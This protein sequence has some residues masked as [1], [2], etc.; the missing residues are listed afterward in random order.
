MK[1]LLSLLTIPTIATSMPNPLLAKAPLGRAKLDIDKTTTQLIRNK[2][3]NNQVYDF[4]IKNLQKVKFIISKQKNNITRVNILKEDNINL[5]GKLSELI[6]LENLSF[7][8]TQELRNNQDKQE[9]IRNL[10]TTYGK[11]IQENSTHETWVIN[12]KTMIKAQG[13]NLKYFKYGNYK[14][15]YQLIS[16]NNLEIE[17]ERDRD[18]IDNLDW[19]KQQSKFNLVDNNKTMTWTRPD[20][21]TVKGELN[22]VIANPNIDKVVF[23]NI[24]QNQTNKQWKINVKPETSEREHNLQVTFALNGKQYTSEIIVS[25]LAKIEPT[26]AP[27]KK[28]LSELIKKPDLGNISDNKNDNI[29]LAVNKINN[30][31]IDDFSQIEFTKKDNHSVTL[32][33]KKDSK[34]YQG[35]VVVKYNV[36]PSTVVDLKINLQP[37]ATS[38]SGVVVDNDYLAQLDKNSITNPVNKFHYANSESII[39]MIKS[40]PSSVITGVVYGCDEQW[41]KT[42]QQRTIDPVT[43]IK[44]DGIQLNT[45]KGKY[46]IELKNEL[47]QTS[48][49][50]LQING[51]KAKKEYWNTDNGKHFEQW[52][53]DNGYKNIRGSSA[54]QLNNLFALSKT[55]KQSLAHLKLQLDNFVV[56][57]IKNVTQDEINTYKT[58]LLDDVK[59]QVEK[60]VPDVIENIDYKVLADNLVAGDW[61]TSKDVKVQAVNSSTKLL[62]F[63]AKTI[64]VQQKE[65]PTLPTP[66][67]DPTPDNKKVGDS[68]L[69]IIGVVVGVLAGVGLA[70]LL[71]RKFIFNKY[72]L[73]KI[74]ARRQQKVVEQWKRDNHNREE[75]EE[76]AR[77][78]QER[79]E[80]QNKQN[81]Q[82]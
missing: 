51:E 81:D 62:S 38:G 68:K 37:T 30:D 1:K 79:E 74:Y 40:N 72:I 73:P 82:R 20:L 23:D 10:I 17:I 71:F 75:A 13:T 5:N 60:Y 7:S 36:V 63:T 6:N 61:T 42:P 65:Q 8:L 47:N 59:S 57:D 16:T 43:G 64:P 26:R 25:M 48:T 19:V 33:A 28:Q 27:V 50:Y 22:I 52:A 78:Q 12:K 11:K 45:V 41:N 32:T 3:Q 69:W 80:K 49:I 56:D 55:W 2:R 44:L 66:T 77:K 15:N 58:K 46:L 67:F 54:S 29:F 34:S 76:Q 9:K 4:E 35:S 31:I 53:E 39:K 21:I 14:V 24:Q 70:P 18:S